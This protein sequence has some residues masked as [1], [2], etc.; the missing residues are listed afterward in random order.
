[1]IGSW[2]GP[3][4]GAK[5]RAA[6]ADSGLS[7]REI[8]HECNVLIGR[9]IVSTTSILYWYDH[10]PR[11]MQVILALASVLFGDQGQWMEFFDKPERAK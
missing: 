9:P 5:F 8:T 3:W 11:R 7:G 10:E 4:S 2:I 1:M 6:V